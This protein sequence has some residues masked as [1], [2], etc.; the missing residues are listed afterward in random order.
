MSVRDSHVSVT[1][2]SFGMGTAPVVRALQQLNGTLGA[3]GPVDRAALP[4]EITF[5][6]TKGRTVFADS[7]ELNLEAKGVTLDV[8]VPVTE[9]SVQAELAGEDPV[10]DAAIAALDEEVVRRS[11]EQLVATSWQWT[12]TYSLSGQTPVD[13]PAAYTLDCGEDGTLAIQ[14]DCNQAQAEYT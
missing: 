3:G 8:R 1:M 6:F 7:A 14:A 5:Q 13:D 12:S 10:L 2:R 11:N 9:E 4:G